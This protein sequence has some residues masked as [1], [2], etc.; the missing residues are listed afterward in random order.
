M[1]KGKARVLQAEQT[2]F[3]RTGDGRRAAAPSGRRSLF[4]AS[5]G[6]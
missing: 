6:R 1:A 3:R 2:H 5:R 4:R